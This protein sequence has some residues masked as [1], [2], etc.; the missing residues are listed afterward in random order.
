M[1]KQFKEFHS[2]SEVNVWFDKFKSYFPSD[3][4]TDK[5]FLQAINLYTGHGNR[6]FNNYLRHKAE[7]NLESEN[8]N[9]I[10]SY[11]TKMIEQLPTYQI[12]DNI[13]VYLYINKGILKEICP[14]YPPK[15]EIIMQDKGFTSTTLIRE[16]V[17]DY[18]RTHHSLNILL[19]ISV[20]AGT[21]GIYVGHLKDT[22]SEY[23]VI[24][25]PNTKLRIDNRIPFFNNYFQCTVVN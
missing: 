5:D 18:R 10:Y 9:F 16:S 17:N 4:D 13:I 14:S 3:N 2:P 15:K 12:P 19:E 7:L 21:K 24:L 1:N 25:A 6:I 20:P 8:N 23:E 11:I 22:L